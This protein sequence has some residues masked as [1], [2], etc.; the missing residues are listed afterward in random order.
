MKYVYIHIIIKRRAKTDIILADHGKA[1]KYV[2]STI[3]N[4]DVGK[5]INVPSFTVNKNVWTLEIK[6]GKDLQ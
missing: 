2:L 4:K 3:H 5:G 6:S 1:K